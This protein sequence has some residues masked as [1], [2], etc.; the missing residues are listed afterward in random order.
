M[1]FY[2]IP[3]KE[4]FMIIIDKKYYLTKMKCPKKTCSNTV[5]VL[6]FGNSSLQN[7]TRD[8]QINKDPSITFIGK[9]LKILK[10]N[11]LKRSN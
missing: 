1:M 8:L 4:H 2:L 6:I 9:Y 11:K 5:L 10:P 3:I 7:V